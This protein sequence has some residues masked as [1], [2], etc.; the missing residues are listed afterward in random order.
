MT[1][2]PQSQRRVLVDSSAFLA[3]RDRDDDNHAEAI[4]II[5]QLARLRYR[6]YT[7]NAMLFEAHAPIL[8][9]LGYQQAS[10]FLKDI[11][12]RSTV[13][14]RVRQTDEE[15]AKQIL[16]RYT[17]KEFSCND[18]LSFVVMERLGISQAFTFDDDFAQYGLQVLEAEQD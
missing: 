16:H 14:I 2:V 17:D 9:V 1:M 11:D 15:Q 3:L 4:A 7:T 10:Q 18:A 13:V 5:N 12:Q 8:S 6:L